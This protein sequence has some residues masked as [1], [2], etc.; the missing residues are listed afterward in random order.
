[1]PG[2]FFLSGME[3]TLF[4]DS[5]VVRSNNS[6]SAETEQGKFQ[7]LGSAT[8]NLS[9]NS[10]DSSWSVKFLPAKDSFLTSDGENFPEF[11]LSFAGALDAPE[12]SVGSG[13]VCQL[14]Q[15]SQVCGAG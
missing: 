1:M 8:I 14:S 13:S 6:N 7:S 10:I 12:R 15:H 2:R 3:W 9:A 4:L 11:D 5:G